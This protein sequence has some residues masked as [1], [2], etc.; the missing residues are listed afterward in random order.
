MTTPRADKKYSLKKAPIWA[1]PLSED[2]ILHIS[3]STDDAQ[4]TVADGKGICHI[5]KEIVRATNDSTTM[6]NFRSWD[7]ANSDLL[8]SATIQEYI[9]REGDRIEIH[10]AAV[11][12]DGKYIDKKDDLNLRVLDHEDSSQ[13]GSFKKTQKLNCIVSGININDI[14]IFEYSSISTFEKDRFLDKKYFRYF[15]E[16]PSGYWF[17]KQYDFKLIQGRDETIVAA[18]KFFRDEN[19]QKKDVVVNMV[20]KGQNYVFSRASLGLDNNLQYFAPYIE[21]ATK[22]NWPEISNALYGICKDAMS[23]TT[24][25]NSE[26]YKTLQLN[27]TKLSVKEKIKKITDFVQEEIVYLYDAEVMHGHI[28]QSVQVTLESKSGDC[29]AKSLLV[30]NLLAT[31]GVEAELLFVNYDVNYY[32][33]DY[34]P[35]PFV[36]NHAIV[37]LVYEGREYFIDPTWKENQGLI[38]YR[39]EP[40]FSYYLPLRENASLATK[41]FRPVYELPNVEENVSITLAKD[42]PA[43]ISIDYIYR[44]ESADIVRHN[45]KSGGNTQ[46]IDMQNAHIAD[47]LSYEERIDVKAFFKNSSYTI[48]SDD[49][50]KNELTVRYETEIVDSYRHIGNVNLFRYYYFAD[51]DKIINHVHQ[52]YQIGSFVLY[53][54][55]Y[56][57]SIVSDLL[58]NRKDKITKRNTVIDNDYFHFHNKKKLKFKE[59]IVDME[60]SPKVFDYIKP[61]DVA[62]LK[63]DYQTMND[64]NFGVGA[65]Y[66]TYAQFLRRYVWILIV[67][68]FMLRVLFG[69]FE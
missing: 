67:I 60:Y 46:V 10:R 13:Y 11:I 29:K 66:L 39:A 36:F 34:L 68:V 1:E 53:P 3:I 8:Q 32:I 55:K 48:V 64:S 23:D 49:K 47:K 61:E 65:T 38:G 62:L 22:A 5:Y 16:L 58:L 54:V 6:Y 2:E 59:I 51:A 37:R 21:I 28:P 12:R 69:A 27:S 26:L 14:F 9:L 33:K 30:V 50:E 18:E 56:R 44:R 15:C 43:K 35:S 40:Y 24:L 42:E 41:V 20:E 52:D 45:V 17:Y 7:I 31:I 19:G 63:K 57:L 4:K 25:K